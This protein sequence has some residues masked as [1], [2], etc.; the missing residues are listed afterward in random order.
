MYNDD[1]LRIPA[2]EADLWKVL[3]EH[4]VLVRDALEMPVETREQ[5]FDI[6]YQSTPQAKLARI[7]GGL[8]RYRD[9]SEE[10]NQRD[11]YLEMGLDLIPYIKHALKER[12][13][14]PEFVQQ[15]GKL[16]FCFGY[17]VSHI[18]DDSDDLAL[19]RAGLRR[20]RQRSKDAQ[21]KWITHIMIPLI[22]GGMKRNQAE[23]EV[24]RHV[25]AALDNEALRGGFTRDWFEPII[26]HGELAATYDAKHFAVKAMRRLIE[27]PTDDIP[28][29][30]KIP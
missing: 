24:V 21:R 25:T 19:M 20:G 10:N 5:A 28:P 3:Q 16:M 7:S 30:P 14:T 13:L 17:T 6:E 1:V 9:V 12:K 23:S 4:F 2:D 15:W 27:E 26:T 29:I 22:D 18:F 11:Y 8:I